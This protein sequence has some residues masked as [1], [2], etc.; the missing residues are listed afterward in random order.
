M[1]RNGKKLINVQNELRDKGYSILIWDAYR[2]LEAQQRL[3]EAYPD[4]TFVADPR[5][6]LTS[7]SC[8]NTVDIAIVHSDGSPV[9]LPSKFDE[10]SAVADRDY[11]DVSDVA[12][13]NARVLEEVMYNNGFTG[14]KGEWWDYS[15]VDSYVIEPANVVN[16]DF[17]DEYL[18]TFLGNNN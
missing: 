8:G 9:E 7:H 6:G 13:S 14:Y 16:E 11:T 3:W 17:G 18:T 4:P 12:A 1:L 5:N 2:S 10:F 15:D